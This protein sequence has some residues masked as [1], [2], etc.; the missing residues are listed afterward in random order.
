M[1]CVI[2]KLLVSVN[3]PNLPHLDIIEDKT[4][5]YLAGYDGLSERYMSMFQRF[6]NKIGGY[7]GNI[8]KSIKRLV[9]PAFAKDAKEV[10]YDVINKNTFSSYGGTYETYADYITPNRGIGCVY[11][12]QAGMLRF[13]GIHF[14][15]GTRCFTALVDGY[16]TSNSQIAGV[17]Y[18]TCNGNAMSVP[19]EAS[20]SGAK[21]YINTAH[22]FTSYEFLYNQGT[23][24][25]SVMFE[26]DGVLSDNNPSSFDMS[27]IKG[28][29]SGEVNIGLGSG[30]GFGN[31]P[32]K[33]YSWGDGLTKDEALVFGEAI[34]KFN[35]ELMAEY[36]E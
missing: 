10:F 11:T 6:V 30:S 16:T 12:S 5:E 19:V 27:Y 32:V 22:A 1:K 15:K 26:R 21:T 8:F 14:S 28:F 33:M 4:V 20:A 36:V 34:R 29:T 7:D 18:F 9:I 17:G 2:N 25:D 31:H 23:T 13:L 3:N 24:F 35:Q